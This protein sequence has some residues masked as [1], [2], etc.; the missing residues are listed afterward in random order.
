MVT[1]YDV[2]TP[3]DAVEEA[4]R[5]SD[6]VVCVRVPFDDMVLVT[7]ASGHVD[8]YDS[9]RLTKEWMQTPEHI[10]FQQYGFKWKIRNGKIKIIIK[11][12]VYR[13]I[14]SDLYLLVV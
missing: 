9:L 5:M 14:C 12:H 3:E 11:D 10:F 1:V 4:R 2:I 6:P 8:S 7:R 13:D